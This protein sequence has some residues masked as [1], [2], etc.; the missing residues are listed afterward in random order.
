MEVLATGQARYRQPSSGSRSPSTVSLLGGEARSLSLS[1]L[2]PGA[3]LRP[4]TPT[5]GGFGDRSSTRLEL[6]RTDL[7]HGLDVGDTETSTIKTGVEELRSA[8]RELQRQMKQAPRAWRSDMESEVRSTQ[9]KFHES[10]HDALD[11]LAKDLRGELESKVEQAVRAHLRRSSMVEESLEAFK[12]TTSS[13]INGLRMEVTSAVQALAQTGPGVQAVEVINAHSGAQLE[14][15]LQMMEQQLQSLKASTRS[16][17]PSKAMERKAEVTE[18]KLSQLEAKLREQ[19]NQW[20]SHEEQIQKMKDSLMG[21]SASSLSRQLQQ[22]QAQVEEVRDRSTEGI[23]VGAS[24]LSSLEAGIETWRQRVDKVL[25]ESEQRLNQEVERRLQVSQERLAAD[26]KSMMSTAEAENLRKKMEQSFAQEMR[27]FS[28]QVSKLESD[29]AQNHESVGSNVSGL[30]QR[31]TVAEMSIAEEQSKR[32]ILMRQLE[33]RMEML[34]EAHATMARKGA[35]ASRE[36]ANAEVTSPRSREFTR[37]VA[38]V[39]ANDKETKRLLKDMQGMEKALERVSEGQRKMVQEQAND[40][41]RQES[42]RLEDRKGSEKSERRMKARLDELEARLELIESPQGMNLT[43]LSLK[44]EEQRRMFQEQDS[45]QR[46]VEETMKEA[47]PMLKMLQEHDARLAKSTEASQQLQRQQLEL[48]S[49]FESQ[50]DMLEVRCLERL[51]LQGKRLEDVAKRMEHLEDS[52]KSTLLQVGSEKRREDFERRLQ[53]N[54]EHLQEITEQL[55]KQDTSL[56]QHGREV[57]KELQ[58]I[59]D[60]HRRFE[61]HQSD[62]QKELTKVQE[63]HDQLMQSCGNAQAEL[64]KQAKSIGEVESNAVDS[65]AQKSQR[66]ETSIAKLDPRITSLEETVKDLL[67]EMGTRLR[68][69]DASIL[70][71][72]PRVATIESQMPR[73]QDNLKTVAVLSSD[74][75]STTEASQSRFT[76]IESEVSKLSASTEKSEPAIERIQG[77]MERCDERL[78]RFSALSETLEEH[79][80][81][82]QQSVLKMEA[83]CKK[84]NDHVESS[85]ARLAN[86]EYRLTAFDTRICSLEPLSEL[87]PHLAELNHKCSSFESKAISLETQQKVLQSNEEAL[88]GEQRTLSHQLAEQLLSLTELKKDTATSKEEI[89]QLRLRTETVEREAQ[90]TTKA[91]EYLQNDIT[92]FQQALEQTQQRFKAELQSR[93]EE[94]RMSVEKQTRSIAV[95]QHS[96]QDMEH[97]M[98]SLKREMAQEKS[99]ASGAA[100]EAAHASEEAANAAA[101]AVEASKEALK[102]QAEQRDD[103]VKKFDAWKMQAQEEAVRRVLEAQDVALGDLMK[104][105]DRHRY[106]TKEDTLKTR[107]EL[108]QMMKS[109]NAL[110]E[111]KVAEVQQRLQ[112]LAMEAG[113]SLGDLNGDLE[114]IRRGDSIFQESTLDLSLPGLRDLRSAVSDEQKRRQHEQQRLTERFQEQCRE[115]KGAPRLSLAQAEEPEKAASFTVLDGLKGCEVALT[116]MDRRVT[117][118]EDCLED[119]LYDLVRSDV[120]KHAA[121]QQGHLQE[122]E[123]KVDKLVHTLHTPSGHEHAAF[124]APG[125]LGSRDAWREQFRNALNDSS[126]VKRALKTSR[127]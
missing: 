30:L 7:L 16:S 83:T 51:E 25:M 59:L 126:Y 2:S 6:S 4:T 58:Q 100:K 76:R 15:R 35:E 108:L 116:A 39:E 122:M 99:A 13:E 104:S 29:F 20:T 97:A 19:R 14:S 33:A 54:E 109:N 87:Q 98:E 63:L 11:T 48:K 84:A 9:A 95:L 52:N 55:G 75:K 40:L 65:I 114:R 18:Q 42:S 57:K 103:L 56:G 23:R 32:E 5:Y 120:N 67:Q 101:H 69:V 111:G 73:L 118:L 47:Q 81:D 102:E 10:Q 44:M 68:G 22:L 88:L 77:W 123:Q 43:E 125:P 94:S 105:M 62:L 60:K 70:Q 34:G 112:L 45:R 64:N 24:N 46:Q 50:K 37:M 117:N 92:K 72:E 3:T 71:L 27:Q 1:R 41:T 96:R 36:G 82:T 66:M 107:E 85:I 26:L 53:L 31:L 89:G 127:V 86:F 38:Q 91:Q 115:T 8:V 79:R 124:A 17:S 21:E 80:G 93:I 12:A 110:F 78:Q 28:S 49:E 119:K 121:V 106:Q 113:R 61:Q 90:Q 74:M